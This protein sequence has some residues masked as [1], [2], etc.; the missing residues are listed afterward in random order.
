MS[1]LPLKQP[2]DEDED[3]DVTFISK[4]LEGVVFNSTKRND[5]FKV[6]AQ[7]P[8][9]NVASDKLHEASL[10]AKRAPAKIFD[11]AVTNRVELAGWMK[12]HA[13]SRLKRSEGVGAI[14]VMAPHRS[15]EDLATFDHKLERGEMAHKEWMELV[16]GAT[17]Q[18]PIDFGVISN[19]AAKHK[20]LGGKWLI[21]VETSRADAIWR[22]LAWALG[23]DKFPPAVI[24]VN[25]TP[26]DDVGHRSAG[27]RGLHV[28]SVWNTDFRDEKTIFTVERAIRKLSIRN[29]MI[30]KSDVYSGVGIYR[31]NP[32]RIRPVIYSSKYDA[33][34]LRSV[35]DSGLDL[36][37]TFPKSEEKKEERNL[38]LNANVEK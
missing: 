10:D 15:K 26:V 23:S 29:A 9:V 36:D 33:R 22:Q 1:T 38:D 8:K 12:G 7:G 11:C 5:K 19:L 3:A 20:I 17:L 25:A 24:S 27:D 4:V 13:P 31:N 32:W 28:L 18:A 21:H 16:G 34:G 14:V 2:H 37:W 6:K 35:I 30:Y